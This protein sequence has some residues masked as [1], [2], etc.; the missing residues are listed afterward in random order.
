MVTLCGVW[1]IPLYFNIRLKW[2]R[3]LI[4]WTLFSLMT[5]YIVF[6]ATRQPLAPTTPRSIKVDLSIN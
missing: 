5:A 1:L 3:M 6:K 4:I 2:F